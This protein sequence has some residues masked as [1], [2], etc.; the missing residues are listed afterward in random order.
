MWRTRFDG[1]PI[2]LD[3]T[4]DPGD[5]L[6]IAVE[7]FVG[8]FE[9]SAPSV[10]FLAESQPFVF[11][12]TVSETV[13]LAQSAGGAIIS[14][15]VATTGSVTGSGSLL[16]GNSQTNATQTGVSRNTQGR[17]GGNS[18]NTVTKDSIF[19][20]TQN[21]PGNRAG[22]L[23][24]DANLWVSIERRGYTGGVIGYSGDLV[25]GIDWLVNDRM[26]LGVLAAYG[27]MDITAGTTNAVIRSPSIGGY[28]GT[29]LGDELF[30]DGF[31]SF[32][33]PGYVT[34][35][36]TFSSGRISAAFSVT[37]NQQRGNL[38][39][40]SY[41]KAKSFGE[42]QPAF[43]GTSGAVP[44][45]AIR[46]FNISLGA[47]VAPVAPVG[48]N[49][50]LPYFSLAIDYGFS[51]TTAAGTDVFFLPR[52]GFGFAMKMGRGDLLVDIDTGWVRSDTRDLG[53]RVTYEMV[54]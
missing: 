47:K 14:C 50:F 2:G 25:G 31:L 54:F 41:L 39:L 45:N 22:M 19:V 10:G 8:V 30:A 46:S 20:S 4:V 18:G 15:A 37:G 49:E 13:S 36:T 24:P 42:W 48:T 16:S 53:V 35:G 9:L 7:D 38:L 33:R 51:D 43:V 27:L 12:A 6:T 21:L 29:R 34:Q 23:P 40:S 28:F 1:S 26:V 52:A 17:L 11:T 3:V 44:A 32:A 5:V